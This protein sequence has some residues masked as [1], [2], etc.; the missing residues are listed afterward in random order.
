ML[1][2]GFLEKINLDLILKDELDLNIQ[3]GMKWT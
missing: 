3:K 1:W 2:A